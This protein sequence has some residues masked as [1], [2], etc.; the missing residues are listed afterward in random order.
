LKTVLELSFKGTAY[1]GWQV[2]P[3]AV[4]VQSVVQDAVNRVLG[5]NVTVTGCSRTDAGVHANM[6]V[7]HLGCLTGI[8]DDCFP[9]AVNRLLPDDVSVTRAYTADDEFHARYDAKGKEYM[10]LIWN[11]RIK[12]VFYSDTAYRYP[13]KIDTELANSICAEFEGTHDFASCMA[14]HSK[15]KDTTVRTVSYYKAVRDGD[16]VKFYVAADGFLYNM[17]RIMTGTVLQ[18]M[19]GS[20]KMPARDIIAS[21]DRS[22]A[23]FTVPSCG[24]YLNKVIY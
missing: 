22:N 12:N 16:F 7:C 15:P 10:Y 2:Q 1:S 6:F 23:G 19:S 24:L 17:V 13:R 5:K 4:S 11:S 8:P 3:D 21:R 14:A 20:V 9:L 18:I